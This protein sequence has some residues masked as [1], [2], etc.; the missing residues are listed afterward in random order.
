M[1]I[2]LCHERFIFRFGVDRQL[3]LY[4]RELKRLGHRVTLIGRAIDPVE[5][6]LSSDAM[7]EIP[8]SDPYI[9]MDLNTSRWLETNWDRTFK[10]RIPDVVISAGWPFF[11]ALAVFR[12]MG[13]RTIYNDCGITP[14][15]GLDE[16]VQRTLHYLHGLRAVFVPLADALVTNSRFTLESQSRL[17]ARRGQLVLP[18]LLSGSHAAETPVA[19]AITSTRSPDVVVLGRFEPGSYKQS[20]WVY[21]YARRLREKYPDISIGV[22]ALPD[23]L[24]PHETSAAIVPLGHP[25]DARLKALTQAA[26]CAVVFSRWEGFDLPLAEAAA[27]GVHCLVLDAGA[28]R[29]VV[30]DPWY[31]C[32]DLDEITAKSCALL[33][34]N[35]PPHIQDKGALAA[36][37]AD[38][39]WATVVDEI[40]AV[41]AAVTEKPRRVP[42]PLVLRIDRRNLWLVD[43]TN[44]SR[45]PANSGVVRVCRRLSAELQKLVPLLFV[46]WDATL[47]TFRFPTSDEFVQ[48]SA[49]NGPLMPDGHPVSV[50]ADPALLS[51]FLPPTESPR[52]GWLVL[53]EIRHDPDFSLLRDQARAW[54]LRTA[55]IFHD[56][57]PI[58]R[59]DLVVDPKYR[60][61]H[62][63]YMRGLADCTLVV[64]NSNSSSADLQTLWTAEAC[65]P[66]R[67]RPLLLPGSPGG[68]RLAA[69]AGE[70]RMVLCVSTL[71]PRKGHRRLID[72]FLR[73]TESLP[74]DWQLVLIGNRYAGAT[75]VAEYVEE[76][77]R[78]H[79]NIR[80]LG[81]VSDAELVDAYARAAFTVYPSEIEGFGL[82]ILE[83]LW[84]GR[85][86]L[87]HNDGV[88][89][90]LAGGGGCYSADLLHPEDFACALSKLMAD[91]VLRRQLEEQARDRTITSWPGYASGFLGLLIQT[92]RI[93]LERDAGLPS[94]P[95]AAQPAP[96]ITKHLYPGCL[97]ENWQMSDS[98]RVAL[99][100]IL[101]L[102]KPTV[103]IEVGTFCGGSLSLIRQHARAVFSIDIDP[104]VNSRFRGM[105]NVTFLTGD[106]ALI[107]P[108]L[109]NAL[110]AADRTPEFILIDGD[111]SAEGVRRDIECIL[112]LI[113]SKPCW[114][115]LHDSGNPDCRHG[116][117]AADWERSP[118]FHYL[119][120]DFI[121]GR[122]TENGGPFDGQVWG[123]LALALFLPDPRQEAAVINASA[124]RMIQKLRLVSETREVDREA[125]APAC[126][127]AK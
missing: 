92:K 33:S 20:E 105:D 30:P 40:L 35:A 37:A 85:P 82:P 64:P 6:P 49:Y 69:V 88:M 100:A 65:K 106:S 87:C 12:Q 113:P 8:A 68:P 91:P 17:V 110:E 67:I 43:V 1:H 97:L 24:A 45:D 52:H 117:Q 115:F 55:A 22:L 47:R 62:R 60:D 56:A 81:I 11:S 83:S 77:T 14:A 123:G 41:C 26:K 38:R 66:A 42:G 16:G 29:E 84:Y 15:E 46:V 126:P 2:L 21:P 32:A 98:E 95:A 27:C 102:S 61:N 114:V 36:Y 122:M 3:L 57:I 63:D 73:A 121:P 80:W 19:A 18:V 7:I 118:Y 51:H 108:V 101:Q 59:P 44:A 111:H 39:T 86:C 71:E 79:S 23:Q 10:G 28:H 13:C 120:L 104:E 90:E 53:P 5:G 78:R 116:M 75:D 96:P 89:A 4:G 76:A 48:L 72:A 74:E 119:D 125:G 58:R 107:L 25:D 99:A 93:E 34:G 31:L 54:G 50:S 94:R 112:D 109:L 9:D 103:A 70:S 127:F 124:S